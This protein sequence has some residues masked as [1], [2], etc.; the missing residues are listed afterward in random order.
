MMVV[1]TLHVDRQAWW[2][3]PLKP[4]PLVIMLATPWV[5]RAADLGNTKSVLTCDTSISW[6]DP[7]FFW[8]NV[9]LI[10]VATLVIPGM[11]YFYCRNMKAEKVRRLKNDV[12]E[13]R[14]KG[15]PSKIETVVSDQFKFGNYF[16]SMLTLSLIVFLGASTIL[17]LKPVLNIDG[18]FQCGVD[19]G[20]GAN[21]LLL[22]K[23]I[24][25]DC[26]AQSAS[27]SKE[28]VHRL[29]LS[30][31]AFQFGFLGAYV[32]LVTDIVRGF[33]VL[34]LSPRTVVGASIRVVS[35]SLVALVVSFTPIATVTDSSMPALA[36]FLG[37]FPQAAIAFLKK[38]GAGILATGSDDPNS[39]DLRKLPGM[40]PLHQSS[41]MRE[42][43]D[44]AENLS[45]ARPF[46]LVLL[47]GFSYR[48]IRQWV[49]QAWLCM[50]LREQDYDDFVLHTG[51][52]SADELLYFVAE[53][54]GAEALL[55]TSTD[56]KYPGK[57]TVLCKLA[58]KWRERVDG[59]FK[60]ESV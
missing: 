24:L 44:N 32:Y 13:E 38:W 59:E 7:Y 55:N 54:A 60:P 45:N 43:Y 10:L 35:A 26:I 48:Q 23:C 1:K 25:G 20:K 18:N 57:I 8:Y 11:T 52:T 29:A 22:G 12:G 14:W 27:F 37:L 16:W 58:V 9:V 6:F 39:I 42:G 50:H 47:T 51:I 40:S 49:G 36:F 28:Y 17:L 34:D 21:T 15:R 5:A 33:F 19:F 2:L 41:L 4:A 30:L 3:A 31:T 53:N 56:N 46:D